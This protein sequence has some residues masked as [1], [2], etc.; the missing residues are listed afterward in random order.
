MSEDSAPDQKENDADILALA[1]DVKSV[2]DF[3]KRWSRLT[4]GIL[5]GIA[6][7]LCYFGYLFYL[8]QLELA[9][10]GHVPDDVKEINERS[11]Q[12]VKSGAEVTAANTVMIKAVDDLKAGLAKLDGSIQEG[13]KGVMDLDGKIVAMGTKNE[14]YD[15]SLKLLQKAADNQNEKLSQLQITVDTLSKAS[16]GAKR[17]VIFIVNIDKDT[18]FALIGK[19]TYR[20]EAL[21]VTNKESLGSTTLVTAQLK[22]SWEKKVVMIQPEFDRDRQKLSVLL[23]TI[24][25]FDPTAFGSDDR[26]IEIEL[27]Y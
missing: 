5:G 26:S 25:N 27:M 11:N 20:I 8:N 16:N 3:L 4:Y 22:G 2:L 12:L 18:K 10:L 24:P 21:P 15:S 1:R 6:T 13:K 19:D 9:S 17:A 14:V 23:Q 7:A